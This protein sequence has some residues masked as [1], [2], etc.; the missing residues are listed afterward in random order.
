MPI[1]SR[2]IAEAFL[3]DLSDALNTR[4]ES[5]ATVANV[6]AIPYRRLSMT[7]ETLFETRADSDQDYKAYSESISSLGVD[8][9]HRQVKQARSL[10]ARYVEWIH[11]TQLLKNGNLMMPPFETRIVV[12][13]K[14][15][16]WKLIEMEWNLETMGWFADIRSNFTEQKPPLSFGREDIRGYG[17]DPMASYQRHLDEIALSESM[18]DFETYCSYLR[19]PHTAH[20]QEMDIAIASPEDARP[21]FDMIKRTCNGDVV[22]HLERTCEWAEFLGSDLLVGYHTGRAYK[23]GK[24]VIKPVS[25]RMILQLNG[26]R[27]QLLSVANSIRNKQYPFDMYAPGEALMTDMD[28]QKRTVEWP[29]FQR[30]RTST[31]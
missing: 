19:F 21:F 13:R 8:M 6:T 30:K 15:D 9:A 24:E 25:S 14:A 29:S 3:S 31:A 7:Q 12:V 20:S 1:R 10:G 18:D 4:D 2:K 22:D 28:I 16:G 5:M 26:D 23:N 11:D 17:L 27:W